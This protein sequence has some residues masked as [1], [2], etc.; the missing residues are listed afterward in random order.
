[1]VLAAVAL[2]F[3]SRFVALRLQVGSNV[4]GVDWSEAALVLAAVL[5]GPPWLVLAATS[6]VAL[7]T[8]WRRANVVKLVYNV[9]TTAVAATCAVMVLSAYG[10]ASL[11]PLSGRGAMALVLA[12]TACWVVNDLGVALA[13]AMSRGSTMTSVLFDGFS[14]KALVLVGN[15]GI[16]FGVLAAARVDLRLLLV[17]LPIL[18]LVHQ[19]YA[20][21]IR[22]RTERRTW[23]QL[24][25]AT[26][27]MSQL[28]VRAV[29]ASAVAGAARLFCADVVE[30][31]INRANGR[32]LHAR[33][34]ATSVLWR[35]TPIVVRAEPS[36]YAAPLSN[37][38]GGVLGQVRLCFRSDFRLGEREQ[39]ALST[40]ADAL[41]SAL[42][43]A[44]IHEQLRELADRKAR[45]AAQDA[46]TGLANRTNLL[47]TG[48]QALDD[49]G[50]VAVAL[51]L[52]DFDHFK[53]VNDTL[54]HDAGD[55]MLLQAATRMR[56][57][58]GPGELLARLGGDEF[59]LLMPGLRDIGSANV[60]ARQRAAALLAAVREP[61]VVGGVELVME[62]SVGVAVAAVGS[63]DVAELL[64][65]ADIAMYQAK[66]SGN[67]VA[68]Y[69]A[70]SDEASVDR[71]AVVTE[72]QA[73]LDVGGQIV[74]DFQPSVDLATGAPLGAEAL[75][76]WQ[77]PRRGLLGPAEFIPH[78][79]QTDLIGP[80]TRHVLD[81]ALAACAEW[82]RHGILV[83]VAVNLSARAL[84][85]R[86][87]P[88]RVGRLL[89]RYRVPP[90]M[91]VLEITETAMMSELDVVDT[92]LDALRARGVQLSLDDFGTGYSSLTFLARVKPDEVKIDR[93]FVATMHSSREAAA[94]VRTTIELARSLGLRV[95]AEG[96]ET[97]GQAAVLAQL[98][99]HGAQGYH[100]YPPLTARH[101]LTA[102]SSAAE[103]AAGRE[104][105]TVIPLSP[106]RVSWLGRT[107][108]GVAD[109]GPGG[110]P[111][112][113]RPSSGGRPAPGHPPAGGSATPGS[114]S[115]DDPVH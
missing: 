31:E 46:L 19:A 75:V 112:P 27:S 44:E 81:L 20:G 62:A 93:G 34:D 94:I 50:G 105:A 7:A 104:T 26:H 74:L 21:R 67:A 84:L 99:C 47:E 86:D 71:L 77:H 18:W 43:N 45:E 39:L 59:G 106:R 41:A 89:A 4:V 72:M 101:T 114:R 69:D 82:S 64:R 113:G 97:A 40:F 85:D 1:P 8:A 10:F 110:E 95:I 6:G 98:G 73:A 63:C 17:V 15:V 76:R 48:S 25:S 49:A 111:T 30:V 90:E 16:A 5:A 13:V 107:A 55:L 88:N 109:R 24:A 54:G 92:V 60:V 80:L 51:L 36:V 57:A 68:G 58:A 79:E 2:V 115:P 103:S 83:P 3:V 61:T 12:A 56:A 9:A 35:A 32:T 28:D 91:L 23:Q 65:R 70:D 29:V 52:L 78:V 53:Q 102:L 14:M 22:A 96:V 42:R 66:G 33:G 108:E 11:D 38:R 100:L 37:G 87:L